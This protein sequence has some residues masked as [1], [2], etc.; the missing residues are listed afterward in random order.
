MD[1]YLS[2]VK[3]I[4]TGCFSSFSFSQFA[5]VVLQHLETELAEDLEERD[6][7]VLLFSV[8]WI[9]KCKMYAIPGHKH[10]LTQKKG[11]QDTNTTA[12]ETFHWDSSLK[13]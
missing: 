1:K 5:A 4:A 12:S 3:G 7:P 8:L 11:K 2:I 6:I 9:P 13:I 10:G